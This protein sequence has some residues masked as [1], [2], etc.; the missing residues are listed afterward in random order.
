MLPPNGGSS[1]FGA[2]PRSKH[3]PFSLSKDHRGRLQPERIV[4]RR[5]IFRRY[6]NY[7]R[8]SKGLEVI[9]QHEES[10]LSSPFA[11]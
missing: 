1:N 6:E 2:L 4:S 10:N 5:Y 8:E 11:R 9:T 7:K 3:V